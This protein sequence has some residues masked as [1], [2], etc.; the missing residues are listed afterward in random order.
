MRYATHSHSRPFFFVLCLLLIG[1]GASPASIRAQG[2][3][4]DRSPVGA[5]QC[6]TNSA[7]VAANP[8]P[9]AGNGDRA[10]SAYFAEFTGNGAEGRDMIW[11]GAMAGV[12]VGEL[13][14]RLAHVGRDV[15]MAAPIWPVE[16][17]M[18]VSG[19][20]PQRAFVAEVHGTI[21]WL[22]KRVKLVGE[23]S[24]GYM[25][26]SHVEQTADLIDHDVSGELCIVPA[27]LAT[28]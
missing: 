23:V 8:S 2:P 22:R 11:R 18:F 17:I 13:T 7:V 19:E 1:L 20:N 24:I 4:A 21:D 28:R 16:G 25:R 9:I 27:A 6:A 12:G 5:M 10:G 26:G 15:D 14:I 3:A